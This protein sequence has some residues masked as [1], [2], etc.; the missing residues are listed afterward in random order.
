MMTPLIPPQEVLK[1]HPATPKIYSFVESSRQTIRDILDFKDPRFL[2]IVGPCSIHSFRE[3]KEFGLRLKDLIEETKQTF[4]IVMRTYFEKA[5]TSLGWKGFYYD[6]YLDGSNQVTQGLTLARQLLLF[7]A[8]QSIPTACEF[9]DPSLSLYTGDL[10]SWG[11]VGA[12]TAASQIHRQMASGLPMPIAFKNTT[13]GTIETAVNG[14]LSAMQPH[15][16]VGI[17]Y[18]GLM[19]IQHTKGNPYA[20]LALRGGETGPNYDPESIGK[21][22]ELLKKARVNEA[23]L[24]DCSHDNSDKRQSLQPNV[25][26]SLIGQYLEGN[27]NIRGAMLESYLLE[28]NQTLSK[29]LKPGISITDECLSWEKTENLIRWADLKLKN[30]SSSLLQQTL[31]CATLS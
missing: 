18:E 10:I 29:T 4:F 5:R 28:G 27:Q 13:E 2:L 12:R 20:H 15:T 7:L 16:Y 9:L 11:C 22:L 31:K 8:E 25:F 14:I 24:V 21:G 6:P 30:E 26:H 17:N 1:K 19:A 23:V 3:A